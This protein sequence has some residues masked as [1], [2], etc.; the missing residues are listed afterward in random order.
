[1]TRCFLQLNQI[2]NFDNWITATIAAT[3]ELSHGPATWTRMGAG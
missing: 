1:L 2:E 3:C